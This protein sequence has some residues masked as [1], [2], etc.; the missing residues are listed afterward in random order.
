M[1]V[2]PETRIWIALP[3][4]AMSK[5]QMQIGA[6]CLDKASGKPLVILHDIGGKLVMPIWIGL[7]E[8]RAISMASSQTQ[9]ERP[10]TYDLMLSTIAAMGASI[11]DIAIEA[12]DDSDFKAFISLDGASALRLE[13][14]PADAVVLASMTGAPLFVSSDMF[15][16]ME[17]VAEEEAAAKLM[18]DAK[19]EALKAAEAEKERE[20]FMEFLEDVKPSDFARFAGGGE[21]EGQS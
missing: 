1:A 15:E 7:P 3:D 8:V 21:G 11:T 10:S 9:P 16:E 14:R 6:I 18:A 19:A 2:Q 5:K 4:H 20:R 17:R 12:N 13:A